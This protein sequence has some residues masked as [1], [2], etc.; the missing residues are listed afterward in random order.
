[1]KNQEKLAIAEA[2]FDAY[3]QADILEELIAD[4]IETYLQGTEEQK[5]LNL[6]LNNA[7]KE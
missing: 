1:M 4:F 6:S 2:T 7:H 3:T 5:T